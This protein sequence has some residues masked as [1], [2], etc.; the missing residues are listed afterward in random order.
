MI[1]NTAHIAN[2][3]EVCVVDYLR[4]TLDKPQKQHDNIKNEERFSSRVP[5]YIGVIAMYA[6]DSALCVFA[7]V[8]MSFRK[9]L[10]SKT[11]FSFGQMPFTHN[12]FL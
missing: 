9:N 8:P 1:S 12:S 6:D 4:V 7:V 5:R 2:N 10:I 11:Q 3:L